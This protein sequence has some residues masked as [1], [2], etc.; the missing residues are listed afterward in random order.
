[1][2]IKQ[3]AALRALY[4]GTEKL[5]IDFCATVS[6]TFKKNNWTWWGGHSPRTEDIHESFLRLAGNVRDSINKNPN[7]NN[8][9]TSSGRLTVSLFCFNEGQEDEAYYCFFSLDPEGKEGY[10]YI[11]DLK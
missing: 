11:R 5:T 9:R 10:C 6:Q 1:M 8:S 3:R 4:I 7:I 2:S